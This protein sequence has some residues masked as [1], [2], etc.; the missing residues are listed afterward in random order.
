MTIII[1]FITI[2]LTKMKGI[3]LAKENK[4]REQNG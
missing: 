3:G 1:M 2:G 4:Y